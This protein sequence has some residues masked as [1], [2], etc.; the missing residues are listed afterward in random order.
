MIGF[1]IEM[2]MS[3]DGFKFNLNMAEYVALLPLLCI[4][5]ELILLAS[6][7]KTKINLWQ[8]ENAIICYK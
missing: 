1:F 6:T 5:R 7:A 4:C 2:P 8:N 3:Q